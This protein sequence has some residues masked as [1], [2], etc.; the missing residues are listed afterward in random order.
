MS[1]GGLFVFFMK[2]HTENKANKLDIFIPTHF[3]FSL[4]EVID[5]KVNAR[6]LSQFLEIKKDFSDWIKTQ[7]ERLDLV[8]NQD[9]HIQGETIGIKQNARF[10]Y[11]LEVDIAKEVAMISHT[12]RGK[13]ARKYFIECEKKL[14]KP[15]TTLELLKS[16]VIEL[17]KAEKENQK[18]AL[19]NATL[20]T[21]DL[22][23]KTQKEY[24]WIKEEVQN[25]RGRAIN[26][27]VNKHFF[28]GDYREAHNHA[29][30][31]FYNATGVKLPSN[32][33]GMSMEQKKDYLEFLS[34]M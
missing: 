25:D 29:K 1:A 21:R 22:E 5:G 23:V 24:K 33:K 6:G 14:N 12:E 7:I 30:E 27:Y 16:A 8:E 2:N 20:A 18:L 32:A 19:E 34:K 4:I 11:F 28:T 17:E 10:E 15:K 3:D 9:Y 13:Q 31:A 26:Y